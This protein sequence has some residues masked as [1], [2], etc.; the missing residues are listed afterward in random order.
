MITHPLLDHFFTHALSEPVREELIQKTIR[1]IPYISR[2]QSLAMLAVVNE[3]YI[4]VTNRTNRDP[5][6]VNRIEDLATALECH[7]EPHSADLQD[8]ILCSVRHLKNCP[9]HHSEIQAVLRYLIERLESNSK[10]LTPLCQLAINRLVKE[11]HLLYYPLKK[12][13]TLYA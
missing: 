3:H 2:A 9:L 12:W 10:P 8:L 11:N 1:D 4:Y 13:C 5:Y 7:L 6:E